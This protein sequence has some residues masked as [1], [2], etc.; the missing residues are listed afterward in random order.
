MMPNCLQ[1]LAADRSTSNAVVDKTYFWQ[2][3]K[4]ERWRDFRGTLYQV[5]AHFNL[6]AGLHISY[7]IDGS[8]GSWPGRATEHTLWICYNAELTKSEYKQTHTPYVYKAVCVWR[9]SEAQGTKQL[10][11]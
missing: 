2:K 8:L 6:A 9:K 4:R 1:Q 10:K 7:N 5:R 3:A 11:S